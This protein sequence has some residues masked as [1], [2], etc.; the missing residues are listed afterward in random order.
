M[1]IFF[2]LGIRGESGLMQGII[3][4]RPIV[5]GL[6]TKLESLDLRIWNYPLRKFGERE[7]D[8]SVL[9]SDS[10]DSPDTKN[11]SFR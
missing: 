10:Q 2:F 9:K 11:C 1:V 3:A 8:D 5:C 7:V 6:I 4:F